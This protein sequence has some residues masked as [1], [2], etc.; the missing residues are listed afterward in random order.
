MTGQ[1][2]V[3]QP[4][5]V[6]RRPGKTAARRPGWLDISRA[7]RGSDRRPGRGCGGLS[8]PAPPRNSGWARWNAFEQ[9]DLHVFH[10]SEADRY[11]W[12]VD[13]VLQ[14]SHGFA[15]RSDSP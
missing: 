2:A 7:R 6:Q 14:W 8:S 5:T 4:A 12:V 3:R 10:G 15:S 11:F 9:A 13:D 1:P